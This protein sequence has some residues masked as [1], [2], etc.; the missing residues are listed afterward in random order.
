MR[1]AITARYLTTD[2]KYGQVW[3]LDLVGWPNKSTFLGPLIF[4]ADYNGFAPADDNPGWRPAN[5]A[6]YQR[7]V[8][9]YTPF[10]F[11]GWVMGYG[12][13][14]VMQAALLLDRM[15]DVTPM[16]NWTAK[17]IYDP[18]LGFIVPE[19]VQINPTGHFVFRTGDL[20]NGVQEAEIVKMLR[21]PYRSR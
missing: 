14:F 17:E 2:T 16:L 11:Y 19:G 8:D 5:E 12:Q 13:G 3:T 6:A 4:L 18:R 20:G 9:A 21:I 15:K 7:L 10:G 1:K